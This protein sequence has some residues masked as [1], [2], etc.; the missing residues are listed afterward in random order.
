VEEDRN[1]IDIAIA[2]LETMDID[3]NNSRKQSAC[4]DISRF[5]SLRL[6]AVMR[7]LQMLKNNLPTGLALLKWSLMSFSANPE[8]LIKQERF[9]IRQIIIYCIQSVLCCAK[10]SSRKRNL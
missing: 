1:K 7:F 3:V 10:E 2:K 5:E 6:L 8:L 4:K 9:V